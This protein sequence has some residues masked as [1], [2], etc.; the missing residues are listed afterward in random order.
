[1]GSTWKQG[2]CVQDNM[3]MVMPCVQL[4]RSFVYV[5]SNANC[6]INS[7]TYSFI[8]RSRSSLRFPYN[9]QYP[10]RAGEYQVSIGFLGLDSNL[11]PAFPIFP[12]A[13]SI[14]LA[15]FLQPESRKHIDKHY[16]MHPLS[17]HDLRL[18]RHHRNANAHSLLVSEERERDQ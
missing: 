2:A 1:M 12:R 5:Q 18:T 13:H 11:S 14:G 15:D 7:N 17:R 8:T 9:P 6:L 4:S 3:G 10:F 16:S